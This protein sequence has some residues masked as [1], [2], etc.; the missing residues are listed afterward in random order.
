MKREAAEARAVYLDQLARR[1]EATWKKVTT[2]IQT[3]QPGKYDLAVGLL[4]D[5]R[6]LAAR[7]NED[8]TF[9]SAVRQLRAAHTAKPSFIRRMSEAGL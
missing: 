7:R 9:Q 5:L 1:Q 6:D 3:K 4:L 8:A 2:L